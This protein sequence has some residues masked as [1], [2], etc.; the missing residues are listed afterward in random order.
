MPALNLKENIFFQ[1][2]L[3]VPNAAPHTWDIAARTQRDIQQD[4]MLVVL[5]TEA[6]HVT[7]KI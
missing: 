6:K 5:N 2:L 7:P 4:I 1:G 3:S